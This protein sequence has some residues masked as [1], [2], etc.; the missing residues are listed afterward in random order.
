MA[1]VCFN[2]PSNKIL[3]HFWGTINLEM[4]LTEIATVRDNKGLDKATRTSQ[5]KL[6]PI[7]ALKLPN[8]KEFFHYN[9]QYYCS[10][11]IC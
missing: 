2:F 3:D 10:S 4:L 5:K 8:P 11:H 6:F 7:F 1:I 9:Q